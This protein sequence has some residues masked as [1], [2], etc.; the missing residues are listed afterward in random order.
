MPIFK[1]HPDAG[2]GL[3]T[4]LYSHILVL[5]LIKPSRT[6]MHG[7]LEVKKHPSVEDGGSFSY[8]LFFCITMAFRS[9]FLRQAVIP[10]K[11]ASTVLG[12]GESMIRWWPLS[13]DE[14]VVQPTTPQKQESSLPW[15][16]RYN[17]TKS[18][19]FSWWFVRVMTYDMWIIALD[20]TGTLQNLGGQV[21]GLSWQGFALR[22]VAWRTVAD[23]CKS[24]FCSIWQMIWTWRFVFCTSTFKQHKKLGLNHFL[25]EQSTAT[26]Q[27][28]LCNWSSHNWCQT[29]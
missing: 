25:I 12:H 6:V 7:V 8:R 10:P 20:R 5:M 24:N 1:S 14:R 28:M 2:T 13:N 21:S 9:D 4:T 29:E 19:R 11:K 18:W 22:V 17:R 26:R 27:M 16:H 23:M 15:S 3:D